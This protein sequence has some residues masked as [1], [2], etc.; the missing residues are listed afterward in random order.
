MIVIFSGSSG[1]GKNTVINELIKDEVGIL[2]PTFT[3]RQPRNGET[4]GV[5][6]YFVSQSKFKQMINRDEFYEYEFIHGKNYYGTHKTT[7]DRLSQEGSVLL[8]DIDVLGA[9]NLQKLL[10]NKI[11]VLTIYLHIDKNTLIER[12]RGRGETDIEDRLKRFDFEFSFSDKYNIVIENIDL[13]K[14]VEICKKVIE[15]Y[16]NV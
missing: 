9:M 11:K 3:S 16:K 2:M 15:E 12:L 13:A 6:Y 4:E 1:V 8:K 5:P 14:T 7:I 10:K